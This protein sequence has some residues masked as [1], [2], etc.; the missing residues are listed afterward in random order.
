VEAIEHGRVLGEGAFARVIALQAH[1]VLKLTSC[2]ASIRLLQQLGARTRQ[3]RAVPALPLVFE[4]LGV[5]AD[6]AQGPYRGFVVERLFVSSRTAEALA[7][8]AALW[9]LYRRHRGMAQLPVVRRTDSRRLRR[10]LADLRERYNR[11]SS[12]GLSRR[13]TSVEVAAEIASMT[14]DD[15]MEAFAF[16]ETFIAQQGCDLDLSPS[17]MLLSAFGT[18]VF[19]DPV[20]PLLEEQDLRPAP[21]KPRFAVMGLVPVQRNGLTVACRWDT[22]AV[23]DTPESADAEARASRQGLVAVEVLP[24]RSVRHLQR[25]RERHATVPVFA[26]P[27]WKGARRRSPL[28][29]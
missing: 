22:L 8:R 14:D 7:A 29:N 27:L 23:A 13:A 3:N 20:A 11:I 16:L 12:A 4:D 21:Q 18:P 10:L 17:N 26:T 25:L 1:L 5:V 15:M 2:H 28:N 24:Y 9:P 19:A 6:G